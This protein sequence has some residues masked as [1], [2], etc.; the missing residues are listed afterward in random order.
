MGWE[1]R[2][3]GL[4]YYLKYRHGKRVV[5]EYVGG[6]PAAEALAQLINRRREERQVEREEE[7]RQREQERAIDREIDEIEEWARLLTTAALLVSG[8]HMHKGQWR[9]KR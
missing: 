7:R 1:R 5:S 2:G 8:Y 6:G 9:K 4:Y 3:H